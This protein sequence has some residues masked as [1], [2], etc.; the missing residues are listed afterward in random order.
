MKND[1]TKILDFLK[2]HTLAV[3]ST[4][5]KNKTP[6]S[7]LIAYAEDKN[8]CLYFQTGI[9]TRKAANLKI[10]PHVSLVIGLEL[11]DKATLQYE[12]IAEC[13]MDEKE[14]VKCKKLFLDKKS[15]TTPEFLERPEA[16]LFKVKPAWINFSDY[17]RMNSHA[18]LIQLSKF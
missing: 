3:I 14:I 11:K 4:N 5:C 17:T 9:N 7:A 18:T 1:R 6:E 8:L 2:V 13:I 16:I 10:N 15:P 12:G